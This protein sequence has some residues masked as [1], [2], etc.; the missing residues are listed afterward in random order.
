MKLKPEAV[1][2]VDPTSGRDVTNAKEL[3]HVTLAYC[4]GI[5]T[6]RQPSAEYEEDLQMK[7]VVHETRMECDSGRDAFLPSYVFLIFL[8]F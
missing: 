2:I 1:T 6:N 7:F 8:I 5:L 3:R 4:K